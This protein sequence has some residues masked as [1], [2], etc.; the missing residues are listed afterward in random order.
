MYNVM[1]MYM[2]EWIVLCMHGIA[3]LCNVSG[4]GCPGEK[5]SRGAGHSHFQEGCHREQS[6]MYMQTGRSTSVHIYT[7]MYGLSLKL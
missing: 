7:Y 1:Y 3:H 2:Y 6:Y 5:E 4:D